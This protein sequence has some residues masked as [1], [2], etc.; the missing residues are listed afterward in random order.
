V[1]CWFDN[2]HCCA[3]HSAQGSWQA[4]VDSFFLQAAYSTGHLVQMRLQSEIGEQGD[5]LVTQHCC[6]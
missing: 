4:V 5:N 6:S 3:V 1:S 2:A